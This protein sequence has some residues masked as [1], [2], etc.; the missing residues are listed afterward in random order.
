MADYLTK[1]NLPAVEAV[2]IWENEYGPGVIIT[3]G[4]YKIYTTL[5]EPLMLRQVPGFVESAYRNYQRQ[6]PKPIE[7]QSK[8]VTYLFGNRK[9]WSNFTKAFAGPGWQVYMKIKKGIMRSD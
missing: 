3:T 4:H 2:E 6:L 7:T 9:Q 1:Q 5:L 8:F